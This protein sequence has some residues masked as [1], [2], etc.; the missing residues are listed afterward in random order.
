[1]E[2]TNSYLNVEVQDLSE[3]SLV[4]VQGSLAAW[5]RGVFRW[6]LVRSASYISCDWPPGIP[7]GK[8]SQWGP[9]CGGTGIYGFS[10]PGD[11]RGF[12]TFVPE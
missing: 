2:F 11:R 10:L 9:V 7:V 5:G 6:V 3:A 1:M 4:S 12:P 8:V